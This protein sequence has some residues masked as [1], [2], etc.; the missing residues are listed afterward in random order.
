MPQAIFPSSQDYKQL[1]S[2]QIGSGINS[3]SVPVNVSGWLFTILE[4]RLR[5]S[6][7]DSTTKTLR[8]R[9]NGITSAVYNFCGV[10]GT[11]VSVAGSQVTDGVGIDIPIIPAYSP[12]SA[13]MIRLIISNRPNTAVRDF[14]I[15]ACFHAGGFGGGYFYGGGYQRL[16]TE[17]TSFSFAVTSGNFADDS[18]YTVGQIGRI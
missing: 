12:L 14:S 5:S 1:I 16:A 8:I 18:T 9:F 13:A 11:G 10:G 15:N 17:L 3:I 2:A 7:N 6:L 4:A